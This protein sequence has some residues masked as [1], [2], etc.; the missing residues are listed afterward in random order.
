MVRHQ[1]A[2]CSTCRR[3]KSKCD[4][5][6][7]RCSACVAS[8]STCHYEKAPS[9]AYVRSLQSRIHELE[10]KLKNSEG[11]SSP[12]SPILDTS[13][14]INQDDNSISL[15]AQG[16]VIYHNKTSAIHEDPP[17]ASDESPTSA[18]QPSTSAAVE[19]ITNDTR[20][21]LVAN[22]AAQKNLELLTLNGTSP[23][24]DIPPEIC[25]VLLKLHWCWLH[26]SFLFV[27]RP[28]FTRDM[29]QSASQGHDATYCS[30][31]LFKVLCAHSCRFIRDPEALWSPEDYNENF[32]RLSN[33]L[34]SEAKTLLAMETLNEPSIPTIQ[35]LLQQS[36]R[37][38]A[39][40]RS[41]S[42]WL[43][44]GM[45][46]RMAIDLGLHVSPDVLQRHSWQIC[47][48]K[49]KQR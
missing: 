41:S 15:N 2:V 19:K 27:Y 12:P 4:G 36:A 32:S 6:I 20:H 11:V 28:A 35:A 24:A 18:T 1:K 30:A 38:I 21:R 23:Q 33:R 39:C 40:G 49:I 45:A 16:G 29:L 37:D 31:T 44:S 46:F 43:Y 42:S 17:D 3:R 48:Y 47:G 22:A 25:S 8:S 9:I 10:A 5:G 26:P 7:P 14:F 34:M 13:A